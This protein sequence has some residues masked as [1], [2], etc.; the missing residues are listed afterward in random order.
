MESG[1]LGSSNSVDE[2]RPE[3]A[4]ASRSGWFGSLDRATREA[5]AGI[6]HEPRTID[7]KTDFVPGGKSDGRIHIL[8]DG[9]ASRFLTGADGWRQTCAVYL[10]GDILDADRLYLDNAQHGLASLT[11]CRIMEIDRDALADLSAQYPDLAHAIGAAVAA[12]KCALGEQVARLG[13]RCSRDR[14]AHFFCEI[15]TRL[16]RIA[17]PTWRG[18][19]FPI[20]Q[21]QLGCILGMSVVH[22]NR[23]LQD[24][25]A[26]G[27]VEL[28]AQRLNILDFDRLSEIADFHPQYLSLEAQSRP[29][30]GD[31]TSRK[32][33]GVPDTRGELAHRYKNLLAVVQSL[34][35]QTF[36]DDT[37]VEDARDAFHGRLE[38][39]RRSFD[40]LESD[41]W[42]RGSLREV[43]RCA[44]ELTEGDIRITRQ[45][46]DIELGGSALMT[47]ALVLHEL[48]TNA[49]K[50]GALSSDSGKV[51]LF[52]KILD[53]DEHPRLWLQ[54]SE[55]GGPEVERPA[56]T[57]FG[58]RLLT[59]GATM[60]LGGE[61]VLDHTPEGVTWL[62]IAPVDGLSRN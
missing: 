1:L 34:A 15:V 8:L 40:A 62:L 17:P 10:P 37:A 47:L 16:E 25:R 39:M 36:R 24:I 30:A 53:A 49:M 14:M 26:E 46:P 43:V 38:A 20:T 7:P 44:M 3:E 9:W 42:Q 58:T 13:R 29:G 2:G 22:V 41:Q 27:L 57:G 32:G 35:Q 21:E 50:Y 31:K 6:A 60:A 5:L 18:H 4:L 12:D 56:R 51:E 61:V 45:G 33:T 23:T 11:E 48:Q 28:R 59:S 54:W 52:W 19:Y 55:T